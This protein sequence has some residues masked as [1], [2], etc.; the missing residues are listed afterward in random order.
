V[1]RLP[2]FASLLGLLTV[3]YLCAAGWFFILAPWSTFWTAQ[4]VP[5][6]PWSLMRVLGSPAFRGAL[7]GFGALHF[8][9]AAGWLQQR[10]GGR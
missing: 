5:G 6:A 9:V 7:S 2:A 3:L 4:V 1:R 10:N 8:A